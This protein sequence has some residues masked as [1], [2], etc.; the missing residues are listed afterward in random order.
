MT[1]IMIA[2]TVAA[3]SMC[4]PVISDRSIDGESEMRD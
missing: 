4:V 3:V 1:M 2:D